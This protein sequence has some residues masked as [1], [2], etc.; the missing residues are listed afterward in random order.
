LRNIKASVKSNLLT[1]VID[2]SAAPSP[3]KSGKTQVVA[4]SEGRTSVEGLPGKL[5]LTYDIP[6][7]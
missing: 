4:S 2:L 3:S 6:P 7:A 1:L 5:N